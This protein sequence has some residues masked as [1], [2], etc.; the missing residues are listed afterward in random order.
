MTHVNMMMPDE[1]RIE[2]RL[3]MLLLETERNFWR[4]EAERMVMEFENIPRAIEE[5]GYIDVPH[6]G[7][8]ITLVAKPATPDPVA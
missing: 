2:T 7:D 3:K 6:D 1:R 5:Y 4:T 8:R